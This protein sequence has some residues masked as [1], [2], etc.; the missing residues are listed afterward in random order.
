MTSDDTP[1]VAPRHADDQA[2]IDALLD[3]LHAAHAAQ[4]TDAEVIHALTGD[5]EQLRERIRIHVSGRRAGWVDLDQ[6]RHQIL[7]TSR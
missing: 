7:G 6:L 1:P 4:R 3:E 5:L 2:V